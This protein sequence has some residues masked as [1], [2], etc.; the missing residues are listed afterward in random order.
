[1]TIA[2]TRGIDKLRSGKHDHH[3]ESLE[4]IAEVTSN[5]AGPEVDTVIAERRQIVRSA[6][7][8]LSAEQREVIE[9]AYYL[10]LSHSE[11]ALR[12]GQ[13]LGTVK[14]RTRLGMMKLRDML[15]PMLED[16]L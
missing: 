6:L 5:T 8:K 7:E 3:K 16:Q 11:I 13:P 1:M 10:G 12:L 14:T 15:R 2:R 4:A 9:L